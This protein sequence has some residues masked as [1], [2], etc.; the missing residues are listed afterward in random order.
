MY[1]AIFNHYF[2]VQHYYTVYNIDTYLYVCHLSRK[3]IIY[4]KEN[5]NMII[6]S[7]RET[8]LSDFIDYYD[9]TYEI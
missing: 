1:F 5:T 9:Y 2:I 4:N 3:D 8:S 6:F 7:I